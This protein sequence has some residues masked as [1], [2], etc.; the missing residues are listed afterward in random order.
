MIPPGFFISPP[1][2][3][4]DAPETRRRLTLPQEL[5]D[6]VA[7]KLALDNDA[8]DT[9]TTSAML[10]NFCGVFLIEAPT[11]ARHLQYAMQFVK[12]PVH[13]DEA[14]ASTGIVMHRYHAFVMLR[15]RLAMVLSRCQRMCESS[16]G[17]QIQPSCG[18]CKA[19]RRQLK[20][21]AFPRKTWYFTSLEDV[22]ARSILLTNFINTCVSM[23]NEWTGCVRG[24]VL[25]ARALGEFLGVQFLAK[26]P[27]KIAPKASDELLK[28]RSQEK[29]ARTNSGNDE[30]PTRST[31][32]LSAE[33]EDATISSD[34]QTSIVEPQSTSCD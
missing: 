10:V 17:F 8:N 23:L 5:Q 12:P 29:D 2:M 25:F 32:S 1:A 22:T 28:L 24:N 9:P 31:E 21:I 11:G 34:L 13:A 14:N 3:D 6:S 27:L 4:L 16:W 20:K 18:S 26:S 19:V 30:D 7:N 15:K 33:E